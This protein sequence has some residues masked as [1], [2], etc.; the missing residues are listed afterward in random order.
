M[1]KAVKYPKSMG[2]CADLLSDMK[3]KRLAADKVAAEL[4]AQETA[5]SEHIINTLDKASGGAVGKHHKV[6]V[7]VQPKPRVQADKWP[8]FYAYM[9]KSKG[10]DMMQKRLNEGALAERIVAAK[11]KLPPGVEMFNVVKLSLTKV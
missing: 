7:Q 8:E 9:A 3:E 2:A 1:A 10:W 11:G 6:V 5:L 4:K